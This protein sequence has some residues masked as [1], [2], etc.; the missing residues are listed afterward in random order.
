MEKLN[1]IIIEQLF[2]KIHL[3]ETECIIL[4]KFSFDEMKDK[5]I[6][7]ITRAIIELDSSDK[8]VLINSAELNVKESLETLREKLLETIFTNI[9]IIN[10]QYFVGNGL[11]NIEMKKRV[12]QELKELVNSE[13]ED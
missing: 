12:I 9:Y 8:K 4:N 6:N 2:T 3:L 11:S 7:E 1:E 13:R 5:A 10:R